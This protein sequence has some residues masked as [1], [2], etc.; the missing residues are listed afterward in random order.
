MKKLI[1]VVLMLMMVIT[2]AFA[3]NITEINVV[4]DEW[5]DYTEI[6]GTGFYFDMIRAVFEPVGIKVNYKHMPYARAV[7]EASKGNFDAV[8]GTSIYEENENLISPT[9]YPIEITSLTVI[10]LKA[11]PFVDESSL[12]GKSVGWQRGY[13]IDS[14]IELSADGYNSYEFS[15]LDAGIGMMMKGRLDFIVDYEADA[16]EAIGDSGNNTD[17]FAMVSAY[18]DTIAISFYDN[19][20]GRELLKIYNERMPELAKSG[21]LDKIY[22]KYEM[23][24]YPVK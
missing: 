16:I 6:D 4:T 18:E 3:G 22:E 11:N 5:T 1:M 9:A 15:G 2:T 8:L 17:D 19:A 10:S 7:S 21:E 23:G 12:K 20:K 14:Y 24:E 13:A